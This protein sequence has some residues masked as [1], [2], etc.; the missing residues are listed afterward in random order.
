MINEAK[1]E[2]SNSLADVARCLPRKTGLPS[3]NNKQGHKTPSQKV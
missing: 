2:R 3:A 1:K